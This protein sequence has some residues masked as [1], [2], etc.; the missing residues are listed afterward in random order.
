MRSK[1]DEVKLVDALEIRDNATY[2]PTSDPT[3]ILIQE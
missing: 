2:N 3:K 1:Y